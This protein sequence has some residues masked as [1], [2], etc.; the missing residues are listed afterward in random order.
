[1]RNF[2][3]RNGF[4][5]FV[6]V[7]EDRYDPVT[8][9]RVRVRC[10]GWHTDDKTEIP[11]EDLPWAIVLTGAGNSASVSGVGTSP[12]GMVE[13]SWVVGFFM[14]GDRAQEPV[15]IGTIPTLPVGGANPLLG[16]NDP[17]GI[18]P[19][20]PLEPDVNRLSRN[21]PEHPHDIID[22][23]EIDR[24]LGVNQ[25]NGTG[26]WDEPP[27]AYAAEYPRNHVRETES[28]HVKEY[29]DTIEAERIHE[30]HKA[31]TF[32]EIQPDGTKVTRVVGDDY[33]VVFQNKNIN[34]KGNCNLTIDA[35]CTTY[36]KGDWNIQVDGDVTEV[37]KG[38]HSE[39]V[40]GSQTSTVAGNVSESYGSNQTTQISGN[41]D[42]DASRIDLN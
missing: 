38:N 9:G 15:I 26:S 25:A 32:Y 21:N 1:M 36:I 7:V 23:K 2:L 29:D 22:L 42:V 37:I 20:Y 27:Y 5:W 35:N 18:Y 12:T 30:Y 39:T 4:T 28:G 11:T 14:D 16:F 34:I 31:G 40:D 6:G 10:F 13:G 33:E 17:F 3:G 8:L 19:K 41:L 24:T